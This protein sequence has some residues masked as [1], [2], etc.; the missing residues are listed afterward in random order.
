MLFLD[1]VYVERADGALCFRWVKEPTSAKLARLTQTLALRI[2]RYLERQGLLERD[3]ENSYLAGDELEGG[4]MAQLL[5]S[6]ITYRI[7][8]GPLT[9]AARCSRYRRCRPVTSPSI[10][11]SAR[12]P[13]SHGT[14]AWQ[15]ARINA[16][17]SSGCA[18]TS[19]GPPLR[20]SACRSHRTATSGT[21]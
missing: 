15:R 20:R 11:G 16:R 17:S 9:K 10:T 3:A 8:V 6:S 5:G 2:G 21:S 19:V 4:T 13:G 14:P 1:G 12:W 7:A 18:A